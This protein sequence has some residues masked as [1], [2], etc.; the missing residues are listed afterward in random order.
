RAFDYAGTLLFVI[1]AAIAAI[2]WSVIDRRRRAYPRLAT[3]AWIVLRYYVATVMF[4][5]GVSKVLKLQF[6][7]LSPGVLHQRIGD[8]PPMR[9]MWAFMGYSQPYT[10]FS[11]L[12]EVI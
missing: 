6:Y 9:L 10:V 3:A 12:A 11:G 5:Y 2:V 7:D 4:S 1:A 8:T